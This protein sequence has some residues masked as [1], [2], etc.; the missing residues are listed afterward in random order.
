M[1]DDLHETDLYKA[2]A[3]FRPRRIHVSDRKDTVNI[4]PAYKSSNDGKTF[5]DQTYDRSVTVKLGLVATSSKM[6]AA[7]FNDHENASPRT[8]SFYAATADSSL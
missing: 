7:N 5:E 1:S 2:M 6:L 4:R 3:D 8:L